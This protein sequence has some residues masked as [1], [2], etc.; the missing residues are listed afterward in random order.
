MHPKS[1]IPY[2]WTPIRLWFRFQN[3]E[4]DLLLDLPRGLGLGLVLE[5]ATTGGAVVFG[6][7]GPGTG[8]AMG[9]SPSP[10]L[11]AVGAQRALLGGG[12]AQRCEKGR[13]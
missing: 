1:R 12:R 13:L 9:S 4:V 8:R 2:F 10:H 5:S 6:G 11:M 3:F 7:A